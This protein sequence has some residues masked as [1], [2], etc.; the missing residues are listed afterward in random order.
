[1]NTKLDA[2]FLAL[3]CLAGLAL[4]VSFHTLNSYASI[5]EKNSGKTQIQTDT[6]H[7]DFTCKPISAMAWCDADNQNPEAI[8]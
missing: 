4:P 5:S 8:L 3:A 6:I 1:M 2:L 7:L